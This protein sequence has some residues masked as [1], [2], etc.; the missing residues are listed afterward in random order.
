MFFFVLFNKSLKLKDLYHIELLFVIFRIN[1]QIKQN[2]LKLNLKHMKLRILTFSALLIF[3]ELSHAQVKGIGD[4]FGSGQDNAEILFKS[5]LAPW[6]NALGASLNGGWYNTAK[7]HKLGGFDLTITASTAIIPESAKTFDLST[8]GLANVSYPSGA[9][10][11][12]VAGSKDESAQ[13]QYSPIPGYSDQNVKINTP[14][15]TGLSFMA[16]PMIQL[17]VGLIKETEIDVR[18]MPTFNILDYGKVGLWGVGVKHSLKQWIPVLEK[19]PVF[20]LSLQGGYT[21]FNTNVNLKVTPDMYGDGFS[22]TGNYDNQSLGLEVNSLTASILVGANLPVVCFYGG[23]GF[24]RTKSNLSL[25]GNF[26]IPTVSGNSL[27]I[28]DVENPIDIE[29]TNSDGSKTKP[30]LNAGMRIK[31]GVLTIHADYTY[32]NYSVAT[33]GIGLSFR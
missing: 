9:E 4:F 19:I 7:P 28:T 23:V 29:I 22:G 5:Y 14:H 24:A 1:I 18:Y 27:T 6:T 8:I 31:M 20:Q 10:T 32:A 3:C 21:R 17:G 26:P 2:Q 11:P 15:G 13:I 30:R 25:D 33:V 16:T 12:T